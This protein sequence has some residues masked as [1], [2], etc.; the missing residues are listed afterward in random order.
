MSSPAITMPADISLE[1]AVQGYFP[2]LRHGPQSRIAL[3][4]DPFRTGHFS[5]LL[6][7]PSNGNLSLRGRARWGTSGALHPQSALAGLNSQL[8]FVLFEVAGAI[9]GVEDRVLRSE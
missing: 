4:F 3:R 9:S 2:A 8:R 5:R 6:F 1:E 7:L